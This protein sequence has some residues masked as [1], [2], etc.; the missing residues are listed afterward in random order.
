M[1]KKPISN[2]R[3]TPETRQEK[4]NLMKMK[5]DRELQLEN[6]ILMGAFVCGLLAT[7][8][9]LVSF[10]S[11]FWVHVTLNS[12]EKKYDKDRGSFNKTGHYH[13]LWRFCRNELW[14]RKDNPN[15]TEPC[16]FLGW[17]SWGVRCGMRCG[18]RWN[19]MW[20]EMWSEMWNEM[21]SE[22]WSELWSEV[23]W[24]VEWDVEWGGMN[25]KWW[26]GII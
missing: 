9:F 21:W 14:P 26:N 25:W 2:D 22:M 20:N 23:E 15:E 10:S 24:D 3:G 13:G 7:L 4:K 11:E 18:V 8:F 16:E 12:P 17:V 6:R 1:D 19:E 5:L